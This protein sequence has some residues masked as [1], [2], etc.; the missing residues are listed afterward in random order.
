[1]G[2]L[3]TFG[4]HLSLFAMVSLSFFRLKT[5]I[6]YL[7]PRT[8]N[9][10][11]AIRCNFES[12]LHQMCIFL[13]ILINL[14]TENVIKFKNSHLVNLISSFLRITIML[15]AIMVI[16]AAATALIPLSPNLTDYFV[17]R[18]YTTHTLIH[19]TSFTPH[20]YLI[21]TSFIPHS[22][23][24]HTSFIPHSYLIHTS[25]IMGLQ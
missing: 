21:H 11:R 9:K 17:D 20:S 15:N 7:W 13:D 14:C 19:G 8:V 10:A 2:V 25:F 4:N 16:C 24:I 23:L 12:N 1:M 5:V 3:S 18:Y 6:Y 22:Y